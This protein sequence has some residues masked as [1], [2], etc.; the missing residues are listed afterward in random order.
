V[1]LATIVS[2]PLSLIPNLYEVCQIYIIQLLIITI[3][4]LLEY[5]L[6]CLNSYHEAKSQ[7]ELEDLVIRFV[8]L[9]TER[10][11]KGEVTSGTLR[12]YLKALKLFCKMNRIILFWDIISHSVPKVKK[13]ANDRGRIAINTDK[14]D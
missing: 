2:V 12:N 5:Q 7:E 4:L 10:I 6:F 11:D 13:H 8:L 3:C 1:S 14:F 9:Q